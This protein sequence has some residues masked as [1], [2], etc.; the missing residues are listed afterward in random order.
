MPAAASAIVDEALTLATRASAAGWSDA[1]DGY[2]DHGC[3]DSTREHRLARDATDWRGPA[4]P[5]VP[6]PPQAGS[7]TA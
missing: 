1:P 6:S 2:R 5:G 4:R 7:T 3:P